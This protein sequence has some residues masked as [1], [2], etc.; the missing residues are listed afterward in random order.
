[1]HAVL[2]GGEEGVPNR[3]DNREAD[4]RVWMLVGDMDRGVQ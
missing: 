2:R 4:R 3:A 1:V